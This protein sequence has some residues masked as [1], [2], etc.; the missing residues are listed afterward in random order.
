LCVCVNSKG[1]YPNP[2]FVWITSV[3][4]NRKWQTGKKYIF[5]DRSRN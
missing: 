5:P 2:F 1:Q 4:T 3:N